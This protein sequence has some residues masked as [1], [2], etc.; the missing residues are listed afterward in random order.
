M[1]NKGRT[2]GARRTGEA[3]AFAIRKTT[4]QCLGAVQPLRA[5]L[6]E[7]LELF[8]GDEDITP[9]DCDETLEA[10][11]TF[12][13]VASEL[14]CLYSQTNDLPQPIQSN[15]HQ[16]LLALY[17]LEDICASTTLNLKFFRTICLETIRESFRA[18][19]EIHETIE[20]LLSVYRDITVYAQVLLD[21]QSFQDRMAR[22]TG[23]DDPE[24]K[25]K[26]HPMLPFLLK[27]EYTTY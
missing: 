15:R 24:K 19:S 2:E 25:A 14:M 1:T 23:N 6:V 18:R 21:K 17:Q 7:V 20:E 8:A 4:Q 26:E 11:W 13:Q 12:H 16:L 27:R 22:A 3:P 5:R 9:A 10:L